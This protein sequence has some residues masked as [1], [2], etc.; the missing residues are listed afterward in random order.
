MK[1]TWYPRIH[2]EELDWAMT[3]KTA[4]DG[5]LVP[6]IHYDEA[7]VP[8]SIATNPQKA[9]SFAEFGDSNVCPESRVNKIFAQLELQMSKGALETD[10]LHAVRVGVQVV[11]NSFGDS[12]DIKD[13]VTGTTIGEILELQKETTD[14]Q[15]YPI[16]TGTDTTA[17]YTNSNVTGGNQHGLTTDATLEKVVCNTALHYDAM[18]YYLMAEKYRSMQ[19]GIMWYTLTRRHPIKTINIPIDSQV[20]RANEYTFFGVR[21][22]MEPAGSRYQIPVD[23][24]VSAISH[25]YASLK[26]RYNEWNENFDFSRN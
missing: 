2:D 10:N 3:C 26:Y 25:V 16:W 4:Q 12:I 15:C 5:T 14:R 7:M 23:G 17:K 6:I 20:K 19:R 9:G 13:E 8:S 22:F 1:T 24:D 18:D 21:V 11:K